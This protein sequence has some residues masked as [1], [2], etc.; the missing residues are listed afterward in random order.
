MIKMRH[1]IKLICFLLI[2]VVNTSFVL[3]SQ[4]TGGEINLIRPDSEYIDSEYIPAEYL[5]T[6]DLLFYTCIEEEDVPVRSSVICHDDN[7]FRDINL[8][9][10]EGDGNCYLGGYDLDRKE[11]GDMVIETEYEKDDETV[12]ISKR[13]EVKRFSSILD[14]VT[15]EQY[16]DG[17]WRNST[18]TASGIWVLSN[19]RK[20]YGDQI[21]LANE[22]LKLNR[23]NENKCWP[24]NDCSIRTT[25]KILAILTL[26]ENNDTSR[27]MHDGNI[28]L[29]KKQNYYERGDRWNLTI[30]PFE[31][32]ITDCLITYER[33]HLNEKE[34]SIN[35]S[36][37]QNYN[38]DVA[39]GENLIVICDQNIDARLETNR[40]EVP[41]VYEGD[42]LTYTLPHACWAKDEK[43]GKCDLTTT[44]YALLTD[45]SEERKDAAL[46]YVETA[47][48]DSS[49]EGEFLKTR[50]NIK[51]TAL[52]TYL[53][54]KE[55]ANYEPDKLI[56]WLRYRQNNEGSWSRG[57]FDDKIKT[58]AFSILG[59]MENDFSR[60][61]EVIRDAENW[62]NRE[63]LKLYENKTA[64][65]EGWNSTENN[66]FAFT[67][68]KNNA[69]PIL[70]FEPMIIVLDET[71][72]EVDVF[73]PT[74][75]PLESITYH[76]SDNLEDKV[77]IE[78][79]RDEISAYSYVKL[80]MNRQKDDKEDIYGYLTIKN[81]NIPI[82]KVPVMLVDH[83][84][85][86][87]EKKERQV[88]IFGTGGRIGFDIEKTAHNFDCR[89][90]W[91]DDEISSRDEFRITGNEIT[92]D[93]S[94][95]E[96]R[97]I[98]TTY[99]GKFTCEAQ[100]RLFEH[101]FSFDASRY[102]SFPFKV[103][104]DEVHI[105]ETG[106]R[107]KFT[108]TN[109]L[110][111]SIEL[112]IE[113]ERLP[114][115]FDL[116]SENIILGPSDE[117]NITIFNNAPPEENISHTNT[118]K[119]ESHGQQETINFRAFITGEPETEPSQILFWI[120]LTILIAIIGGGGYASYHYKDKIKSLMK[121]DKK[122]D[123][124]KMRIKKLEEKE[125]K[126]AIKNMIQI[127][128]MLDKEEK[129]I[130]KRLQEEGFTEE[131]I[132]KGFESEL[133]GDEE[134]AE[135]EE[136]KEQEKKTEEK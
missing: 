8:Y 23:E 93:I 45:L 60:N 52:Y 114:N 25:A 85:I 129:D 61:N 56:S 107:G 123:K 103:E 51:E 99:R 6:E 64:E 80:R 96:A 95:S 58:T 27:I 82:A 98:E 29:E 116:S 31:H 62:V 38:L 16:S 113:F 76:F 57:E 75:F 73:N 132:K 118:I 7:S 124:I 28:Y 79:E 121:G 11:C 4:I 24:K 47:I 135:E 55:K 134:E 108:I 54:G 125:K 40:G 94:F 18:E 1:L 53:I 12:K 10:W 14:L 77:I 119:I 101:E 89:L 120:S 97:R 13:I 39:P 112:S 22:W 49:G 37:R 122:V 92:F 126:T 133:E 3:G 33:N 91:Q 131:E 48:K 66:A 26:A 128:R 87:F 21:N 42:N 136:K 100:G 127:M 41:F 81:E 30:E 109:L 46:E 34:F 19:Y 44:I 117:T 84:S 43:W 130:R 63:E 36:E 74:T 15:S 90:E 50:D 67:V 102:A 5:S 115:Y 69:R 110:E 83:P 20:I 88:T 71:N 59:L 35:Q 68:L 72:K 111:E 86:E 32:G 9:Q 78:N 104:P 105:N 106:E 2:L 17:G 70:K 65:Y